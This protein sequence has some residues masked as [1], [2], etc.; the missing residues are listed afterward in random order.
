MP[1]RVNRLSRAFRWLIAIAAI[2]VLCWLCWGANFL[3]TT[4]PQTGHADAAVVLQGSVIAEKVRL[5][6]AIKL[7]QQGIA[8]HALV[9]VPKESYWGQSIPPIAR[10]YLEHKYGGDLAARVDF[11][12]TG[13]DVN[14]TF[15][16]AQVLIPCIQER[17]WRTIVI[18]TS[19][20]H[21]RRAGIIWKKLLRPDPDIH[22]SLDGVEDPEFEQPWW[23]HRQSAKTFVMES[24]KLVWMLFGG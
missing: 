8:D 1:S 24:A 14:S 23:R 5:D 17:H 18:V 19:D 11:C 6:G 20:Y 16:E 12:E 3:T 2:V 9:S 10:A 21:T 15:Q 4:G 13:D 7:L 22:L